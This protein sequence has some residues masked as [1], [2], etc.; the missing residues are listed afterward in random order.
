MGPLGFRVCLGPPDQKV[1]RTIMLT[2]RE[3]T[4][5]KKN[6]NHSRSTSNARKRAIYNRTPNPKPMNNPGVCGELGDGCSPSAPDGCGLEGSVQR[7][8]GCGSGI[9]D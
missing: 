2:T 9:F 6:N 3:I 5:R 1:L 8:L 7:L 4:M